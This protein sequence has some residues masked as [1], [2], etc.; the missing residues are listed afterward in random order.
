VKVRVLNR[1]GVED[2]E[3]YL[4]SLSGPEQAPVP[5]HLLEDDAC[6]E[7]LNPAVE[8]DSRA[9]LNRMEAAEYLDS[10][11]GAV[12]Q[13]SVTG[14]R[15]LWAWLSLFYFDALCPTKK[16]R[17]TP[18][19]RARWILY[20]DD[21]RK[22]YRHLLAGPYRIWRQYRSNPKTALCVLCTPVHA[23]GEIVE[24]LA[25]RQDRVT[26]RTIMELATALYVDPGTGSPKRGSGSKGS[27]SPR[28]LV[29]YLDQ[30]E[31]SWHSRSMSVEQL[32]VMLPREFGRFAPVPAQEGSGLSAAPR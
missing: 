17:R 15:G 3:R 18:G 28:R 22:Y 5:R 25:S 1:T 27:G 23:P 12:P 11:L 31:V 21:F 2:F 29:T 24:Q 32:L 14:N 30:L 13:D 10:R 6:A 8:V 9:F 16:G 26:N 19:A 4:D 20:A 7:L